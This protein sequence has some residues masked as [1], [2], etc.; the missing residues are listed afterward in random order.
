MRSTLPTEVP[1]NFITMR[2]MAGLSLCLRNPYVRVRAP[3]R[4][5]GSGG[6]AMP[7]CPARPPSRMPWG[8]PVAA[9]AG[10]L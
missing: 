9:A 3:A 6:S 2:A 1:P 4:L 7:G 8:D 10:S 5:P